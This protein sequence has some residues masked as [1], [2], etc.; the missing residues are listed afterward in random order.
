MFHAD[1][2]K[3][4]L[5]ANGL[6]SRLYVTS[7]DFSPDGHE[8]LHVPFVPLQNNNNDLL[9][10]RFLSETF[11][12]EEVLFL[13]A[14]NV[15]RQIA[16][17]RGRRQTVY[18]VGFDFQPDAGISEAI[19]H[20]Y[21]AGNSADRFFRISMQE[22]FFLNCLYML[23]DSNVDIVHVGDRSFSQITAAGLNRRFQ[24]SLN[25]EPRRSSSGVEVTAE[26]TTN[27]F[28]DR[29]RLER[30]IRAAR[31]AGADH[32]K[33][34]KRDVGSFYTAEQLASPYVSPFGKTF[35]DYR[36][37]LEL[38]RDDFE[39]V[40]GL[41]R[42]LGISWFASVLDQPSFDFML[43][44]EP[45]IVKLPST[46]SEHRDY[47]T[48]VA[49][50]YKGSVVLSTGMTGPDYEEWLLDHFVNCLNLYL[51]QC[52][53]AY[54]TPNG[55]CNVGVVRHYHALSQMDP[56]IVPGY[57]SHDFGWLASALA[58]AAGGRMIEKHVKLGNT[59][60][61]HF[62]AVAV[63]LT[64][65]DFRDYVA[66]LREAE[67]MVGSATKQVSPSEHHKYLKDAA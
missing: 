11:V 42:E 35:G 36:R 4:S 60:W 38:G 29:H 8:V 48:Y 25:R 16:H 37:Q 14:L 32:V 51:L 52:N 10:Q 64:T 62:D 31:A 45:K 50:N 21:A 47:L 26:L 56:R 22:F 46:I 55:D 30:M 57:S 7:T 15:A 63:D 6:R 39:F 18:M 28:G 58:I 9:M 5:V 1:W 3:R 53:S 20:D 2:V 49:A 12:L 13:S 66:K 54:P 34:Q 59:E 33:L 44:F 19:A 27:H 43:Q 40:D 23:K 65:P 24:V 61:A 17:A 41:C 67:D